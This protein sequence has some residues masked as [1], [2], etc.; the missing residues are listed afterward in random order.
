MESVT[1]PSIGSI[2]SDSRP[3]PIRTSFAL[4]CLYW[5]RSITVY[6]SERAIVAGLVA[7]ALALRIV[8]ALVT[9][10]WQQPDEPKHFE[11]IRLLVDLRAQLWAE[12]RIV[13]VAD[14]SLPLQREII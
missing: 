9:T 6:A 3:F 14:A 7:A 2:A 1:T 4:P 5:L 8:A 11:Y 10:P 13:G 12:R